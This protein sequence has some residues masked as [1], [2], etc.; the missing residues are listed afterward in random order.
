MHI[1]SKRAEQF[2]RGHNI[3]DDRWIGLIDFV[4]LPPG[5]GDLGTA[6]RPHIHQMRM[7]KKRALEAIAMGVA[8]QDL[9]EGGMKNYLRWHRLDRYWHVV[10]PL[11]LPEG[12]DFQ[13]DYRSI[14]IAT[15]KD[16]VGYFQYHD[17]EVPA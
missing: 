11:G 14:S 9:E 12:F 8:G 6:Y 5:V 17:Q 7:F 16:A 10:G 4:H 1:A 15:V 2:I 3:K 13:R